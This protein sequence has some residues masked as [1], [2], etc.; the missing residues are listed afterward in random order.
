MLEKEQNILEDLAKQLCWEKVAERD[1]IAVWQKCIDCISCM[2]KLKTSRS[3]KFCNSS[4]S[5]PDA[6]WQV[7]LFQLISWGILFIK[8][9]FLS[10]VGHD[11]CCHTII[12]HGSLCFA[13][14]SFYCRVSIKNFDFSVLLRFLGSVSFM[15][16]SS[17]SVVLYL[18]FI[19]MNHST[20]IPK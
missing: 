19:V 20:G 9:W 13:M 10:V 8:S 15:V 1:Q 17:F 2:E 12:V 18:Y 6:G 7:S 3:P 14:V 5:D 4:E 16:C 11:F